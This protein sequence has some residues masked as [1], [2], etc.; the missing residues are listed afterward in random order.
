MKGKDTKELL[1]ITSMDLLRNSEDINNV[2]VRDIIGKAGVNVSMINYHF[3]SK[4]ELIKI[5]LL[6]LIEDKANDMV[7]VCNNMEDPR[8]ALFQYLSDMTESVLSTEKYT[9]AIMPAVLLKDPIAVP[10]YIVPLIS[11]CFNGSRSLQ[12]CRLIAF[13]IITFLQIIFYRMH[14]FS[15]YTGIDINDKDTRSKLI[16]DQLE[17]FIDRAI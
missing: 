6:R 3:G 12:E 10:E 9:R 7:V 5:A 4:D 15:I 8:M 1:I 11:A 13:E 16:S 14:D 17:I 2:T